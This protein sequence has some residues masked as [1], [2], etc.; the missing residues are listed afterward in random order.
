MM[1][2]ILVSELLVV[3]QDDVDRKVLGSEMEGHPG[4]GDD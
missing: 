1:M 3:F 4:N 2:V